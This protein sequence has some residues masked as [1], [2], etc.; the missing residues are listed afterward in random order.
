MKFVMNGL[1]IIGIFDGVNIEICEEVGVENFFFF[2]LIV[3]EVFDIKIKGYKFLD[4]YNINLEL[5][6]VIDWIVSG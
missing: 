3:E 2:G 1:L 5:K 6:V 4:Y